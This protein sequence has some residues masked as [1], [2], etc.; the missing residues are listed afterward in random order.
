MLRKSILLITVIVF[1]AGAWA[2]IKWQV[3]SPD[4]ARFTILFPGKPELRG[5]R[6]PDDKNVSNAHLYIHTVDKKNSYT[7]FYFDISDKHLKSRTKREWFDDIQ[8]RLSSRPYIRINK[9]R[10]FK[11][12]GYPA[13]DLILSNSKDMITYNI[14]YV[15]AK[16]RMYTIMVVTRDQKQALKNT[17]KFLDSFRVKRK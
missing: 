3:F 1:S 9:K 16:S 13:R 8:F 11:L 17:R 2:S 14:R 12:S 5:S 4:G 10:D 7:L 6:R 15:L